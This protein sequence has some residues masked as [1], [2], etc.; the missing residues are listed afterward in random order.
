MSSETKFLTSNSIGL[1][2]NRRVVIQVFNSRDNMDD[3]RQPLSSPKNVLQKKKKK[4]KKGDGLKR[5]K[6]Y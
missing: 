3:T 5:S 6:L 2:K 1:R 4:R